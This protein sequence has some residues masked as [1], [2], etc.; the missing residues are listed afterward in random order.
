[1][2]SIS[3]SENKKMTEEKGKL[4]AQQEIARLSLSIIKQ[5]DSRSV[6]SYAK[7]CLL[8]W[9][10]GKLT[11]AKRDARNWLIY[12][13]EN[14]DQ[15]TVDTSRPEFCLI[16]I[17]HSLRINTDYEISER[18]KSF[19]R[20]YPNFKF[21][22]RNAW[23]LFEK[24]VDK[25]E[26]Y[27]GNKKISELPTNAI[28]II[29]FCN[30]TEES[31]DD[32]KN[33]Q[34]KIFSIQ[35]HMLLG[36][37]KE[38]K[39]L[40]LTNKQEFLDNYQGETL[41]T[42]WQ[43]LA[44]EFGLF[45]LLNDED[46]VFNSTL[47]HSHVNA[48]RANLMN[49]RKEKLKYCPKLKICQILMHFINFPARKKGSTSGKNR[50]GKDEESP[51][52]V[53][54]QK[55]ES[56]NSCLLKYIQNN[57]NDYLALLY[58]AF[59][60]LLDH[61]I[62]KAITNCD[63]AIK[64]Q[65]NSVAAYT[66]RAIIKAIAAQ[67]YKSE[68]ARRTLYL[69]AVKDLQDITGI[70]NN[71]KQTCQQE[72]NEYSQFYYQIAA[73]CHEKLSNFEISHEYYLRLESFKGPND[74][75][76]ILKKYNS[77]ARCLYFSGQFR[78]CINLCEDAVTELSKANTDKQL[79]FSELNRIKHIATVEFGEVNESLSSRCSQVDLEYIKAIHDPG[80]LCSVFGEEDQSTSHLK[81]ILARATAIL[82]NKSSNI[83]VAFR[84]F[85]EISGELRA[86]KSLHTKQNYSESHDQTKCS[87]DEFYY[88]I[89]YLVNFSVILS[90]MNFNSRAYLLLEQASNLI[91]KLLED[92][93]S[94][95]YNRVILC[96]VYV[97][98]NMDYLL[99]NFGVDDDSQRDGFITN[100]SE[101]A[102]VVE[103][104][105]NLFL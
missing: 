99:K 8:Y 17:D 56:I 53:I 13:L 37:F 76:F 19:T 64:L 102:K 32:S 63:I 59:I 47:G 40:L 77:Q 70:L 60:L 55:L 72:T 35:A 104:H 38:A 100:W 14:Q 97:W 18:L 50:K 9:K 28:E 39:Q 79:D 62:P 41:E 88:L 30:Q 71:K 20:K 96:S 51:N 7:R 24:S 57:P 29:N 27:K 92:L 94:F 58:R 44:V 95:Q 45:E 31:N 85:E 26:E 10:S 83:N 6:N 33:F 23:Q 34:L 36:R 3:E 43:D 82:I 46:M 81:L 86:F 75:D 101:K 68:K 1:M 4:I 66:A 89:P 80:Y 74:Y 98:K 91:D 49:N 105:G 78:E 65:P 103:K 87:I 54:A 48:G 90:E 2:H 21:K 93:P 67:Q 5:P 12:A 25:I 16:M 52:S 15:E 11:C 61:R 22:Y 42:L 69:S 73:F 84:L